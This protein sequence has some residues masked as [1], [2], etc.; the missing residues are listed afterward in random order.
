MKRA[1]EVLRGELERR[2]L[3]IQH[4]RSRTPEFAAQLRRTT[5][6]AAE[7]DAAIK[8][9]EA[10]EPVRELV[11]WVAVMR[12]AERQNVAHSALWAQR[13]EIDNLLANPALRALIDE[14][15]AGASTKG[16]NTCE[17]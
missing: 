4:I 5:E 7:L 1:I 15:A 3:Q 16:D 11:R 6:I 9:L 2:R 10:A 14:G 12:R 17:R 13:N 8:L